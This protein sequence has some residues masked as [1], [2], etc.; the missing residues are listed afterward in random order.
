MATAGFGPA[1]HRVDVINGSIAV[2]AFGT[3]VGL[4]Y[5]LFIRERQLNTANR[6]MAGV[7]VG[8]VFWLGGVLT[9]IP[10]MLGFPPSLKSPQ[11]HF[12]ALFIS[13]AYGISLA[14]IYHRVAAKGSMKSLGFGLS[15]VLLAIVATP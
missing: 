5:G 12:V 13:I 9:L 10:I 1:S 3:V 7:V 14:F 11:D 2:A 15:L 4:I 8:L 6:V